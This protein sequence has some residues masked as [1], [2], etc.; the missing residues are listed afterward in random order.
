[1]TVTFKFKRGTGSDPSASDMVVGEPVL[2]TDTAELFFKKD[3]N[4]V[5]KVSGGGG[6]PDFK[7]LDLRNAANNGSASYPGND[8]TLVTSGTTTAISPAAAN[9]LLVSYG[10]VIQKPNSGTSTSGITGFIVDGSRFKTATNLAAAPDFIIYQESGGI[11]E[12]SDNTVTSAKIVDG[13][14]VNADINASA[15]IAGTKISPSFTSDITVTNTQPKISLVDTN[16]NDDFEIKVNAGNFAVNDAT[17]S[18]NRFKIDS[19]G[20]VE[21]PGNLDVGAGLDV[22]GNITVTGTVDGVDIAALNTTVGTKLSLSGGTL[23]GDTTLANTKKVIFNASSGAG[24]YIK[25][26]SGHFEMISSVGNTYFAAAGTL[27]LRSG[28]NTN[29]L[30]LDSSQNATFAGNV[31]LSDSKK[32]Q[33]GAGPDLEIYSDATNAFIKCPDTGNNLTIESDQH[34]YIKVGDS[35]DAIKCVNGQAV[36]LYFNNV[37]TFSTNDSGII[38]QGP[39][40]GS[41][42]VY[43]YADEGDDNADKYWLKT[44]QDGTGFLIQ[45]YV[46]G[47]TET[48]LRAL[49][50]GAVELFYS[51]GVK[52]KTHNNGARVDDC[53]GIGADPQN[54]H[55]LYVK[56]N[57]QYIAGLHN[58]ASNASVYPWLIHKTVDSKQAFGIHFNGVSGDK[59]HVDQNGEV[60][61]G[62]ETAAANA[63]GSYEEGS[64]TPTITNATIS[65]QRCAK[66]TK[67]GN[68]VYIQGH[69]ET[70]S[71]SGTGAVSMGGLPFTT[72]STSGYVSYAC[73]RMGTGNYHNSTNDIIYQFQGSSTN[74]TPLVADGSIN[75]GMISGVH[76]IF[77]GFYHV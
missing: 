9:T 21:V 2:R 3:D 8:F 33:F 12:P 64:W 38:V 54:P 36:E 46:S 47:S 17:N 42:F 11:G 55:P 73:G 51:G 74:I 5:A 7:Y 4:S 60:Y 15:A 27:Y 26:Q 1:M 14:I 45:N 72:S 24:A 68:V 22:T 25:H 40:G 13:A 49:G 61:L 32:L 70:A 44:E 34:L 48:N 43:M 53:L 18:A 35:E 69:F 10:G 67:I 56:H 71:G 19:T 29:A 28:G 52:F 57:Q 58:T 39:E 76:I 20:T 16:A 23:T 75:E 50:N 30:T 59:F 37:K 66:Y 31:S 62:G 77:S 63:L 6:G 65:A 41:A